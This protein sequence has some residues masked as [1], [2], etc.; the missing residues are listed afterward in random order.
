MN[1]R[2]TMNRFTRRC[3][4]ARAGRHARLLATLLTAGI[5][6]TT[7]AHAQTEPAPAADPAAAAPA[8]SADPAT[9][10]PAPVSA[11][12][13]PSPPPPEAAAPGTLQEIVITATRHQEQMS[14]VPVSVSAFSQETLD[15]KG[16]KD[17]TDIA[18]YTPGVNIDTNGTNAISIRGIS[19]S[20]GSGTTGIYIDDTPIQ[21]RALGFNA[22]DTLPKT[23]DLERVEVLRGPQGTLFGAGS[24]GGTVRYI[25][26]QPNMHDTSVYARSELA[27][28]QGGTPSYEAG[29][30]Y[31]TPIVDG[32]LGVRASIWFRH[33]GGWINHDNPYTLQTDEKDANYANDVVLRVA[34]K[35]A[36]NDSVTVTPSIVYQDRNV[37]E[38]TTYWPIL[39]NPSSNYYVDAEP[40]LHPQPDHY[41]LPAIKIE[42]EV[43]GASLISNTSYYARGE[44][45]GYDGTEYNLSYYQTFTAYTPL[46]SSLGYTNIDGPLIDGNGLHLPPAL[47]NYVAPATVTNNQN[48]FTQEIRLQ[49]SEQDNSRFTWTTGL[50]FSSNRQTSVE[51]IN[52]PHMYE[53]FSGLFSPQGV[54]SAIAGST[55]NYSPGASGAI[56]FEEQVYCAQGATV[57]E[58]LL[59]N[60]DS[61]YNYNFSQDKQIAIFGETTVAL[62]DKLKGIVGLRYAK[63]NVNFRHYADGAQNFIGANPGQGTESDRPFTPKLGLSYQADRDD[64]FYTTYAKGYRIGGANPPIPFSACEPNFVLLG[65]PNAPA[66]YNSDT[67]QSFEV[68]AKNNVLDKFRAASSLYYIKWNNIQQNIYLPD[69]GFQF[70][71]NVGKAVAKGGDLQLEWAPTAAWDLESAIGFTDARFTQTASLSPGA[72][73]VASAGDAIVGES[74]VP[75]APWT[76]TIGAQYNFDV[77]NHKSYFRLDWE[78]QAHQKIPTAAED[79]NTTQYD[80]YAYTPTA[81]TFVSLRTGTNLD[82]RWNV[83]A[84]VD[85][86]FDSH[87]QFPPS[88]YAHSDPDAVNYA[89]LGISPGA[90]TVLLRNY[91]FRPRTIG[92]TS[93]YRF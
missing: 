5:G 64:L 7:A 92:V 18:R 71:A 15:L 74:A 23:F 76:I 12:V 39:S 82:K 66:S 78:H 49:S 85:N 42:S 28:T 1:V 56:L 46:K 45:S 31:G 62:T 88:S 86:L 29:V 60:G 44:R 11:E 55:C 53:L 91:T 26:A 68:G 27:F 24:E 81:T 77:V 70:T 84:F 69:C 87:P 10:T 93:T 3:A 79:P 14:K 67:V 19:S 73:A 43:F 2:S 8:P 33:D 22:D 59:G 13:P 40:T 75:A 61:Y 17:F 51:Q 37:N 57:L 89:P 72:P 21:M 35:W 65:I 6:L 58:P 63:T 90:P 41:Y 25:M 47:Q 38:E 9:S 30:A 20:G 32:E 4:P 80:P 52:D 16:V 36:V 54:A 34:A 83:S 48:N 50:F